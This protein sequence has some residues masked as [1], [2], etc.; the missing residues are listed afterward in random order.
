M[1]GVVIAMVVFA[2]PILVAFVVSV[3]RSCKRRNKEEVLAWLGF[4][5]WIGVIVFF[6][7]RGW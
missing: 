1:K 3:V 5:C 7:T 6:L 2:A 4:L